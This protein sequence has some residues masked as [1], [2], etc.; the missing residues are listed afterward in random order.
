M[1]K[2]RNLGS[3][4]EAADL[5]GGEKRDLD[6]LL[7]RRIGVDVGIGDEE[8]AVGQYHRIHRRAGLDAPAQPE[9]LHDV[10]AVRIVS[11]VSAA[12][13]AVGV[14]QVNHHGTD[15]SQSPAHFDLGE[16]LRDTP[17]LH[18]TV[19]LGPVRTIAWIVLGV[20]D[21]DIGARLEPQTMAL[22]TL[23]DHG[24]AADERRRTKGQRGWR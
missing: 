20:D 13:H 22:D 2:Q 1:R 3:D 9:H 4:P 5:F 7:C 17:A 14:A 21:L 10:A 12:E 18:Q 24:G 23:H 8:R 19:V 15:Q 11:A 16:L 6:D